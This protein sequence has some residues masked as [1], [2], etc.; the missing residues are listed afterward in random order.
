M[1]TAA[2]AASASGDNQ[3]VAAVAGKRIR[4]YAGVFSFAGSV[5]AKWRSG[6]TDL[7]GLYYGA[8]NSQVSLDF[9]GEGLGGMRGHFET[10][11]G[12]ALN[13]NLSTNVAV[14][15]HVVYELVS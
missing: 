6:T 4:V 3:V 8:A 11:Q 12:E 5:N 10:A 14:G 2:I 7:T 13:V 15:G 1:A 9:G